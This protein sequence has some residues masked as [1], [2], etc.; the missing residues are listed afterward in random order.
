MAGSLDYR[1]T[2][3]EKDV[4]RGADAAQNAM[5]TTTTTAN[6]LGRTATA[7][8]QTFQATSGAMEMVGVKAAPAM[9]NAVGM[10]TGVMIALKSAAIA[11]GAAL[12]TVAVA[13][14]G[15]GAALATGSAGWDAWKARAAAAKTET[16]TTGTLQEFAESRIGKLREAM[17]GGQME[18]DLGESLIKDLQG[19]LDG[20]DNEALSNALR[21][22][23]RHLVKLNVSETQQAA[24]DAFRTMSG[25]WMAEGMKNPLDRAKAEIDKWAQAQKEKLREV[26]GKAGLSYEDEYAKTEAGDA[27]IEEARKR[28]VADAEAG[29]APGMRDTRFSEIERMGFSMGGSTRSEGALDRVARATERTA[30][31]VERLAER[32]GMSVEMKNL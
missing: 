31:G 29:A 5:R 24:R 28:R 15:V 26:L 1:M 20:G 21:T 16:E 32:D 3:D 10:A 13:V 11:T 4:V 25:D 23:Y 14:L 22:S 2:L 18:K 27:L 8:S 30:S 12:A 17:K 7:V 19:A 9:A 6:S